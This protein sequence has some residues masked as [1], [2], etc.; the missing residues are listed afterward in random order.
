MLFLDAGVI[1]AVLPM[2]A[3]IALAEKAFVAL[4]AGRVEMPRRL[5][6]AGLPAG[7][8]SL[9]MPCLLRQGTESTL[10]VKALSSF[11]PGAG[12]PAAPDAGAVLLLDPTTGRPRALLEA[13]TLTEIRTGAASGLATGLLSRAESRVAAIFGAGAQGRRQ[14]EALLAVRPLE[15]VRIY[16][17]DLGKAERLVAALEETA[18][19]SCAF[20]RA[21]DPR[22]A[23]EGADIVTTAT[24]SGAAVFEHRHL[25]RGVHI[26]AIGSS[27]RDRREVPE[28]TIAAA[29]VVVDSRQAALAEAGDLVRSGGGRRRTHAIHAEI[30]EIAMGRKP[31]RRDPGQT[32]LFKSVGVAVQ[33]AVAADHVLRE[34]LRLGKGISVDWR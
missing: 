21:R 1:R 9:I 16:D 20:R 32:T 5:R 11:P 4:S 10:S 25:T 14:V 26:N 33:D 17:L 22:R 27:T 29:R 3:A 18:G 8:S 6:L 7:G 24:D 15:E 12:V 34:A 28:Q 19:T 30:G 31:G 23:V 2:K 13:A